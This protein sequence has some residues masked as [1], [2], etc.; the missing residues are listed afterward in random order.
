MSNVKRYASK[1]CI[2]FLRTCIDEKLSMIINNYAAENIPK[3]YL[4][5][6]RICGF[7]K[8]SCVTSRMPCKALK[9]ICYACEKLGHFPKSIRCKRKKT[10]S[11]KSVIQEEFTSS[12][13]S[14][15]SIILQFDGGDDSEIDGISA[16]KVYAVNCVIDEICI[17]SNFLRSCSFL[18]TL[19]SSHERCEY[20]SKHRE[21]NCFFCNVRS[22]C[23]R[24]HTE[25]TKGPKSLKLY[26]FT[27]Q[28]FQYE[29]LSWNWELQKHDIA[30]FI[31]NTLKLLRREE[32]SISSAFSPL[33]GRCQ[34]CNENII[35]KAKYI[36]EVN[37]SKMNNVDVSM[38]EIVLK[39]CEPYPSPC[40]SKSIKLYKSNVKSLVILL[41]HPVDVNIYPIK[42]L[43]GREL[44]YLSHIS[45]VSENEKVRYC[46]YFKQGESIFYQNDVGEMCKSAFGLHKNVKILSLLF[47]N[48]LDEPNINT[49]QFVY[50]QDVLTSLSKKYLSVI[51]PD[52]FDEKMNAIREKDRERDKTVKRREMH[53]KIDETRD[54]G[55][56]RKTMHRA[57]DEERDKTPSRKEMHKAVDQTPQRKETHKNID[58][59]RD[60]TL[61]RKEMHR[62]VDEIRDKTPSRKK[63]HKMIDKTPQ[64]REL[65]KHITNQ[66]YQTEGRN[67]YFKTKRDN[68]YYHKKIL[69]KFYN[70]TG[71][72]V[73]CSSCLEY[74][75]R[76]YCKSIELL[77]KD[78]KRK[79][80]IKSCFLLRNRSEKRY[81][82]NLC[83][84]D[85]MKN[86]VPKRS[87]KKN[88]RFAN[89]PT[90]LFEKLRKVCKA[91]PK[92][93]GELEY[94]D[95]KLNRLESFLLKL[96]IPFIRVAHCPRGRYLKLRGDLILITADIVHSLERILPVDQGLIPVCF[97]RKLSYTGSYLEEFIEKQKVEIY[98]SWFK[99]YN[100]L[101]KDANL[102]STLINAFEDD[103]LEATE[104]FVRMNNRINYSE[105]NESDEG[106]D[107]SQSSDGGTSISHEPCIEEQNKIEHNKSWG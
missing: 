63:M 84:T 57:I 75:N 58:E 97:K 14:D 69:E 38:D 50:T 6:C 34:D 39:L 105:C 104:D 65:R 81:I 79:Y 85:I 30:S 56:K 88:W 32:N 3:R 73:P 71:F 78:Q 16:K 106:E 44:H 91:K 55:Q 22:S 20:N 102:D 87:K 5:R 60:R 59:R 70:D 24:L 103:S 93:H 35:I 36:H 23:I 80:T 46:T 86:K 19:S 12:V 90:Y 40:C 45:E 67:N 11:S 99:K 7:K 27:F 98:F 52:K 29:K 68:P 48:D 95:M 2:D 76:E 54:Q 96:V 66:K 31:A 64:R 1:P 53:K 17:V 92:S 77:S 33:L 41:S 37:S 101:F 62:A 13:S 83:W 72:D 49:D 10:I 82:C 107:D 4:K 74:K 15:D 61:K 9:K 28:L 51:N 94:E 21:W 25:R 42:N 89:F 18:W 47:G 26:E 43:W 8:R 100:H